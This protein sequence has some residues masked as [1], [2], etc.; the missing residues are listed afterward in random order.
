L[1][2]AV[3][4]TLLATSS[5]ATESGV[6]VLWARARIDALMDAGRRGAPEQD[7]RAAV[8]DV[9]LTHHLV[10]KFTSLVAVDVTPTKPAGIPASKT[11]VPGNIP[12]GLVGFDQL[13]RTATPAPLMML[14][15]ALALA[16]AAVLAFL[17][18]PAR[19]L[20]GVAAMVIAVAVAFSPDASAQAGKPKPPR[21]HLLLPGHYDGDV[22]SFDAISNEA[23]GTGWFVLVKDAAGVY[24]RRMPL[25][26]TVSC[27]ESGRKRALSSAITLSSSWCSTQYF[28]DSSS[29]FAASTLYDGLP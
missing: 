19:A 9:A 28:F 14:A 8:I 21:N 11:A 10:S 1:N 15:G 6:G 23:P 13:P 4:G 2:G 3:W 26:S 24:V 29:S 25:Y 5:A 12:E 16:V 7:V 27:S 20:A 17:L 22:G 18:R